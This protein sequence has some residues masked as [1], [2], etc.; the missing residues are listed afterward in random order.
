LPFIISSTILL[1]TNKCINTI[2]MCI[3]NIDVLNLHIYYIHTVKIL[4]FEL[5][6]QI[7]NKFTSF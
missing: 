6:A 3:H 5:Y 2:Y 1:L 4:A 7:I